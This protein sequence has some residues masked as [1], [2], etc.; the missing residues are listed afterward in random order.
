MVDWRGGE[1]DWKVGVRGKRDMSMEVPFFCWDVV[2]AVCG[3]MT[4]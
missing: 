3:L 2:R 1:V 4:Q